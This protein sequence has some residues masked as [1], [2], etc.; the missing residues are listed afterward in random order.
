M[1]KWFFIQILNLWR[2]VWKIL[3]LSLYQMLILN[4][5]I[6]NFEFVTRAINLGCNLLLD[7]ILYGGRNLVLFFFLLI[8]LYLQK[9]KYTKHS[10]SFSYIYKIEAIKAWI[11]FWLKIM[12]S[13]NYKKK[14]I[15]LIF[16]G[17]FI[18]CPSLKKFE[19]NYPSLEN[20]R[21]NAPVDRLFPSLPLPLILFFH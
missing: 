9:C 19:T 18:F 15:K 16:K 5:V 2:F 12:L 10:I 13:P 3:F 7:F 1:Y 17:N 8:T 11:I 4:W 20:V 6:F 21:Q 14:L